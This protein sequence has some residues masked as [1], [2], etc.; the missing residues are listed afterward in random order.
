MVGRHDKNG[1]GGKAMV[2][3]WH[4]LSWIN[5]GGLLLSKTLKEVARPPWRR[6]PRPGQQEVLKGVGT[7]ML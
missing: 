4:T 2:A 1:C 3:F 5:E 6:A 7:K